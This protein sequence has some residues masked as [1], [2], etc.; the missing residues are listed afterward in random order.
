MF[1]F[2]THVLSELIITSNVIQTQVECF[3]VEEHHFV[4]DKESWTVSCNSAH[5]LVVMLSEML[6]G[7][8]ACSVSLI[9][10]SAY[11]PRNVICH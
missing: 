11:F 8:L 10:I 5:E 6:S 9:F 1:S 7:E 3:Q 2:F 4:T